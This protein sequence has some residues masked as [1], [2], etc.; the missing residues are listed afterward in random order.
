MNDRRV[1][2]A[3]DENAI[4]ITAEFYEDGRKLNTGSSKI[5][6]YELDLIV[7]DDITLDQL[8]HAIRQGIREKLQQL[9]RIDPEEMASN[10]AYDKMLERYEQMKLEAKRRFRDPAEIPQLETTGYKPPRRVRKDAK[11]ADQD[12]EKLSQEK[13]DLYFWLV[14]WNVLHTCSEMYRKGYPERPCTKIRK[15]FYLKEY[16]PHPVVACG[17]IELKNWEDG[18]FLSM[19]RNSQ[20]WLEQTRHGG[21]TLR[22]LG[23]ATSSR[24]IFDPIAH[25]SAGALF[26]TRNMELHVGKQVP[27]YEISDRADILDR[28]ETTKI[29]GPEPLQNPRKTRIRHSLLSGSAW[30]SLVAAFAAILMLLKPD[31]AYAIPLTAAWAAV[32][33]IP[34]VLLYYALLDR[35]HDNWR[36]GY[37]EYIRDLLRSIRKMQQADAQLM[38]ETYE[39][40]YDP[41]TGVDL[42]ERTIQ[43]S[44]CIYSR[45]REHKDFL[46]V[47]LGLSCEGSQL[48][49]SKVVLEPASA[50]QNFNHYR[51][52]NIRCLRGKPF[53]V[54]LPQDPNPRKY[55]YD[56]TSGQLN[57]LPQELA[58]HYKWMDHVPVLLD[59]GRERLQTFWYEDASKSFLPLLQNLILDICVHHT[60]DD[61]QLVLFCPELGSVRDE[62]NFIRMFKHLPHF[63]QLLED[64]SAFVFSNTQAQLVLDRLQKIRYEREKN[65]NR[66]PYPHTVILVLEEYGLRQHPLSELLPDQQ[67]ETADVGFSFLFFTHFASKIPPYSSRVIK[68]TQQDDWFCVPHCMENP[69]IDRIVGLRDERRYRFLADAL[70]PLTEA[71]RNGEKQTR[72]HQAYRVLS[73]LYHNHMDRSPLPS[74]CDLI[75][76]LEEWSKAQELNARAVIVGSDGTRSRNPNPEYVQECWQRNYMAPVFLVPIG[77]GRNGAVGI[78]LND[79]PHGRHLLIA[80]DHASGKTQSLATVAISHCFHFR[81]SQVRLILADVTQHGLIS[82]LLH[83]PHVEHSLHCGEA[84]PVMYWNQL[85]EMLD[86]E[87]NRRMNRLILTGTPNIQSYNR[88]YADRTV[89]HDNIIPEWL[90]ILDGWEKWRRLIPE[91]GVWESLTNR[92]THWMKDAAQY[93]MH[94]ILAANLAECPLSPGMLEQ[95]S[96]RLCLKME[97][98]ALSQIVTGSSFAASSQMPA[99]GRAYLYDA[100]TGTTEYLQMASIQSSRSSESANA[101]RI[102][103]M[104]HRGRYKP[105]CSGYVPAGRNMPELADVQISELKQPQPAR[106]TERDNRLNLMVEETLQHIP[107]RPAV[108][109]QKQLPTQRTPDRVLPEFANRIGLDISRKL[110]ADWVDPR[111]M[112]E[113]FEDQGAG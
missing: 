109:E 17:S 65:K 57:D 37:E 26:E 99:D 60:P 14:A 9:Y 102:T 64:R 93:G 58:A 39:P 69:K 36:T 105:L 8:L 88:R 95:F 55:D 5:H 112:P 46:Q 22:E 4:T 41:A 25:H 18:T 27:F 30:L 54:L 7:L 103:H 83:Q 66:E 3:A 74:S 68:R 6:R 11:T 24:V 63:Q 96:L 12:A 19:A 101:L 21:K 92:L 31:A 2:T 43:V 38:L 79:E 100:D 106:E 104:D 76:L 80:G 49:E 86:A 91:Q 34:A 59:I 89:Q 94:L 20:I 50:S 72:M 113:D 40:V 67:Q 56:G 98:K 42:I 44:K 47:R 70:F 1:L 48:T 51:Y 15:S 81:P 108:A 13:D 32:C 62:Q 87:K 33:T 90:I 28:P 85:L 45:R 52:Q 107:S 71:E 97:Q 110:P 35:E 75:R 82:Q 77:I 53:R 84:N 61:V 29:L 73:A 23:F 78:A 10:P 16:P 111:F